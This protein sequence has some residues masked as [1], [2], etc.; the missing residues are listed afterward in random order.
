MAL[1]ER[2]R[3]RPTRTR[4]D[5]EAGLVNEPTAWQKR[6]LQERVELISLFMRTHTCWLHTFKK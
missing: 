2:E 4:D 5:R 3:L 6:P 1:T